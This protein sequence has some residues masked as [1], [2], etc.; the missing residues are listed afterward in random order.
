MSTLPQQLDI[1]AH[2][3]DVMLRNDVLSAL[4]R[5]DATRARTAWQA[6]AAAL[7]DDPGQPALDLAGVN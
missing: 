4:E 7:P 1:F 5:R 2:S 6:M 3:H